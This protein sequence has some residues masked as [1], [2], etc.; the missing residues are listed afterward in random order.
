MKTLFFPLLFSIV[1][2]LQILQSSTDDIQT[3][4]NKI[5]NTVKGLE[6]IFKF[7]GEEMDEKAK[8]VISSWETV[9]KYDVKTAT[10][11]QV[12]QSGKKKR[13]HVDWKKLEA[14][15]RFD[16]GEEKPILIGLNNLLINNC[17]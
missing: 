6:N 1:F 2:L 14:G 11:L 4:K 17:E 9:L 13:T 15:M 3:T 16:I 10:F 8:M 5:F 7:F 12:I